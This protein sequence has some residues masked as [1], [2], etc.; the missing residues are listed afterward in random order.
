MFIT[1]FKRIYASIARA[2]ADLLDWIVN[3]AKWVSL[4]LVSLFV[5]AVIAHFKFGWL[6][7]G[8]MGGNLY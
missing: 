8:Y 1:E 3:S 7:T 6:T 2:L 4:I 5:L